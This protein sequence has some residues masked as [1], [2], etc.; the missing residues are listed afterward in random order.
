MESKMKCDFMSMNETFLKLVHKK[1]VVLFE[2]EELLN[3]STE[4]ELNATQKL[5]SLIKNKSIAVS[6][7][8][9][10]ENLMSVKTIPNETLIV[11]TKQLF[12]DIA[13][14]MGF[15]VIG[16][17]AVPLNTEFTAP[18]V[19][20]LYNIMNWVFNTHHLYKKE[21]YEPL[22]NI[23]S[24]ILAAGK[25]T[26]MGFDRPKVLYP[27][28]GQTAIEIMYSKLRPFSERIIIVPSGDGEQEIRA[29]LQEKNLPA[30]IVI[31][32]QP[33][34]TGGSAATV[35]EKIKDSETVAIVWGAQIGFP[36]QALK[37]LVFLHQK[38]NADLS[39]PTKIRKNP[40][41]HLDRD[42]QG[43]IRRVLRE[44]WQ[45]EMPQ[46][47]ENEGGVFILKGSVLRKTLRMMNEA[48]LKNKARTG[49]GAAEEFDLLEIIPALA[50]GGH[51]VLTSSC[52]LDEGKLGFKT[53]EEAEYHE[54]RI[55]QG[56]KY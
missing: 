14:K 42:E 15:S 2:S 30:E 32:T 44:R 56:V 6:F 49:T 9:T 41:I 11:A 31:D 28:C 24:V 36:Q 35:V 33:C 38:Y 1:H 23:V 51:S 52:I 50:V 55:R 53:K 43:V 45:D 34:G 16:L 48:Y 29:H 25:G 40:Y 47:G 18:D 12:V 20:S 22:Q 54:E 13:Q 8:T 26:R 17:S 27:F 7:I 10:K 21:N 4:K 19:Y 37:N 46:Y 39:I 5:L 3:P